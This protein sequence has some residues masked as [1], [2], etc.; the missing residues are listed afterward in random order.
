MFPERRPHCLPAQSARQRNV[1]TVPRVDVCVCVCVCSII[2]LP[3]PG[4]VQVAGTKNPEQE[5][6]YTF[7]VTISAQLNTTSDQRFLMR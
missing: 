5:V 3:C 7:N 6:L 2:Q 4:R 1:L